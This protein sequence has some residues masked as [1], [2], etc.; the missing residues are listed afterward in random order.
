MWLRPSTQTDEHIIECETH[1]VLET[2]FTWNFGII[3]RFK[4]CIK[5]SILPHRY[6][7]LLYDSQSSFSIDT[8]SVFKM[9]THRNAT[10]LSLFW[11]CENKTTNLSMSNMLVLRVTL[12]NHPITTYH[13]THLSLTVC[14]QSLVGWVPFLNLVFPFEVYLVLWTR[15]QVQQILLLSP[16]FVV[17]LW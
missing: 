1:S 9:K 13:T 7:E 11:I 4:I 14:L 3:L 8:T 15:N 17:W 2:T 5:L 6:V 10:H 12:E 16:F